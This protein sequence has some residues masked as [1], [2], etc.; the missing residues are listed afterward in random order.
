M[1]P[2]I[3]SDPIETQRILETRIRRTCA[4]TALNGMFVC[5]CL[6]LLDT[7]LFVNATLLAPN[8]R[9]Y[10][11]TDDCSIDAENSAVHHRNKLHFKVYSNRKQLF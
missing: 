7:L 5:C 6:I 8:T 3:K 9:F 1:P 10:P 4:S 2:N 11:D